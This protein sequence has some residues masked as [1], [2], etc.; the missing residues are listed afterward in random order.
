M[1]IEIGR[2]SQARSACFNL[3]TIGQVRRASSEAPSFAYYHVGE[4]AGHSREK[5]FLEF[6]ANRPLVLSFLSLVFSNVNKETSTCA[7]SPPNGAW[8]A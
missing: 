6:A 8:P 7:Y 5:P 4:K 2:S 3:E 1:V